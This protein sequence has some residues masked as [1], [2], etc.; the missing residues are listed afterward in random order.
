METW[1]RLTVVR[2]EEKEGQWW[3]D[4]EGTRQRTCMND[5]QAWTTGWELTM[6]VGGRCGGMGRGGQRGEIG[7][8]VVSELFLFHEHIIYLNI[9]KQFT[10]ITC[11][12]SE[13]KI[14]HP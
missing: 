7:T 5:P 12:Q 9:K 3:K 6:G 1:I 14:M 2:G 10:F 11:L 8:S 13:I 4:G